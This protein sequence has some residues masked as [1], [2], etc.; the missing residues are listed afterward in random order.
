MALKGLTK[1][2]PLPLKENNIKYFILT[3]FSIRDMRIACCLMEQCHLRDLGVDEGIGKWILR[4]YSAM[5]WI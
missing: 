1:F 5:L 4:K 3:F 2:I